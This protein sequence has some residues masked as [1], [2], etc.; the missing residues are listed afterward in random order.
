MARAECIYCDNTFLVARTPYD[1]DDIVR[2]F[3]F[4]VCPACYDRYCYG[5]YVAVEDDGKTSPSKVTEEEKKRRAKK[6]HARMVERGGSIRIFG[7]IR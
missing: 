4:I 1:G 6:A 7:R 2:L 5:E 3:G